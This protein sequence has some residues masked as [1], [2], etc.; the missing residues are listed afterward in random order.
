MNAIYNI[1]IHIKHQSCMLRVRSHHSDP[2][3]FTLKF[4]PNRAIMMFTLHIVQAHEAFSRPQAD[5][6]HAIAQ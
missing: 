6:I 3:N 5:Y 1:S 4:S 2:N